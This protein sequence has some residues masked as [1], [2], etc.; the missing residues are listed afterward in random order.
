M[1]ILIVTNL[2]PPRILGGYEL[3]CHKIANGLRAR[4]H[5]VLV[6]TTPCAEHTDEDQ[7]YVQRTLSLA[8]YDPEH[9]YSGD[10]HVQFRR[11][12]SQ[13]PNTLILLD[14]LRTFRPEQTMLF[15]LI[16][17]GGLAL[18]D[19][20]ATVGAPWIFN[21]GDDVPAALAGGTPAPIMD[22]YDSRDQGL[23]AGGQVAAVSRNLVE[24]IERAGIDMGDRVTVIPRGVMPIER[25][26][27][28]PYLEGGRARFIVASSLNANKGI[29]LVIEAAAIARARTGFEFVVDVYGGGD[30]RPFEDLSRRF[31]VDD[32]VRFHGQVSQAALF[33]E[34][35]A[36]DALLFPTWEHEPGA[37]VPFEAAALGCLP[38]ITATCGPAERIVDGVHCLK[39]ARTADSVA[40]AIERVCRGDVDLAA[41]GLAGR[42]LVEGDLAFDTSIDRLEALLR[43]GAAS[44]WADALGHDKAA[45]REV[46]ERDASARR[47]LVAGVDA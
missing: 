30:P 45:D 14:V 22:L 46:L 20:L 28:R 4:G 6:L 7:S 42:R 8:A 26:R 40:N 31:G 38:V 3:S 9:L 13:W 23:F 39:I 10:E 34:Y 35:A 25:P 17:I 19:A 2:F 44:E 27:R 47:L 43:R 32:I 24:R 15:N 16:G 37:S 36:S 5:E 12:V 29:D 11:L 33:D 21:L 18:I 41:A 1:R